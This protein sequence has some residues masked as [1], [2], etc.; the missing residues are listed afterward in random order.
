MCG[1]RHAR[2]RGL[3]TSS[4]GGMPDDKMRKEVLGVLSTSSWSVNSRGH[5]PGKSYITSLK[6]V[7]T[8]FKSAWVT[9]SFTEL[10]QA[11]AKAIASEPT[12]T[13][14]AFRELKEYI[15]R[16]FY[17][18]MHPRGSVP[19]NVAPYVRYYEQT[20]SMSMPTMPWDSRDSS[21]QGT[22]L[23]AMV[24][25]GTHAK[26]WVLRYLDYY[27]VTITIKA[28]VSIT[29]NNN[30]TF[31]ITNVITFITAFITLIT[32]ALITAAFT[33]IITALIT[34]TII[35]TNANNSLP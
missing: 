27:F 25:V 13:R 7:P 8:K 11:L 21:V 22:A 34:I 12:S 20:S 10:I 9:M 30:A 6:Q 32:T 28:I 31:I 5:H 18:F 2:G 1:T 16:D 3:D 29:I 23:R 4:K 26:I 35:I 15:A 17:L 33:I 19:L 14:E 24:P